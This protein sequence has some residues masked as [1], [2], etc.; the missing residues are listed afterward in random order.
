MMSQRQ[1][2]KM[3]DDTES[4]V[5][6]M[7]EKDKKTIKVLVKLLNQYGLDGFNL[8]IDLDDMNI[9]GSQVWQGY[10]DYCEEDLNK[11]ATAISTR[12]PNMIDLINRNASSNLAVIRGAAFKRKQ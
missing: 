8:I 12:D 4:V 6:K 9:R 1:P 7:G 5:V 2:I 3:T 10:K 11:F